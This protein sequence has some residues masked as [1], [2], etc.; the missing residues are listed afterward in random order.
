[1]HPDPLPPWATVSAL[2]VLLTSVL[3]LSACNDGAS[4][5]GG[6]DGTGDAGV[7][8]LSPFP[9]YLTYDESATLVIEKTRDAALAIDVSEAE[10]GINV[11]TGP[12]TQADPL[13]VE[14]R[15]TPRRSALPGR[16]R[17]GVQY[18]DQP[19]P[20][21]FVEFT[22]LPA[23]SAPSAVQVVSGGVPDAVIG[24]DGR[25]YGL[26]QR[27]PFPGPTFP[28][29]YDD[30]LNQPF[31]TPIDN[32]AQWAPPYVVRTDG[33]AIEYRGD[34]S[35]PVLDE[36][37]EPATGIRA[38]APADDARLRF[39]VL[40]DGRVFQVF[41]GVLRNEWRTFEFN[42]AQIP[43]DVVQMA[44][45]RRSS[46][47]E[48]TL[49]A[50]GAVWQYGN[51]TPGLSAFDGSSLAAISNVRQI[52]VGASRLTFG[53]ALREDGTVWVWLPFN[54]GARPEGQPQ[55]VPGLAAIEQIDVYEDV[56]LA[57]NAD[58]EVWQV[59][60]EE[61]TDQGEFRYRRAATRVPGITGARDIAADDRRAYAVLSDCNGNG[62]V[63]AWTFPDDPVSTL[64]ERELM[65]GDGVNLI[66]ALGAFDPF[67]AREGRASYAPRPVIGLGE[68]STPCPRRVL[69]YKSGNA[70]GPEITVSSDTGRMHC[71]DFLCA[72]VIDSPLQ[73]PSLAVEINSAVAGLTVTPAWD[74]E[75]QGLRFTLPIFTEDIY[76]KL[77]T[78]GL[79]LLVDQ[80]TTEA[81][82][83][84][85]RSAVGHRI[86]SDPPGLFALGPDQ[87]VAASTLLAPGSALQLVTTAAEGYEFDRWEGDCSE[88]GAVVIGDRNATCRAL[89][90]AAD[91][92]PPPP[93]PPAGDPVLT[94]RIEGGPGAGQVFGVLAANGLGVF[95][96]VNSTEVV[97]VCTETFPVGT[98]LDL[99]AS[100][101]RAGEGVRWSGCDSASDADGT[102]SV[103]LPE[104][105]EIT[106]SFG[107]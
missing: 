9:D 14:W 99:T 29:G 39:A 4:D 74:C 91:A 79:R 55:P 56:L 35:V 97:S 38:F 100:A 95:E 16:Y 104:D 11:D 94:V 89:F 3:C 88:D 47:V 44:V 50:D 107:P 31:A 59:E 46:E 12:C 58:G 76:C 25:L 102:C 26:W 45:R 51:Q 40:F 67:A 15:I 34:R 84:G 37:G 32:V 57:R 13:C 82:G 69:F 48:L 18:L 80:E 8:T 77:S 78:D 92:P 86:E 7:L 41:D 54:D 98:T 17:I 30:P 22:L 62:T 64:N 96:C 5:S 68:G 71:D 43:A 87:D 28:L 19:G 85:T 63:L 1:M 42:T 33:T 27:F 21:N 49:H 10:L 83:F 103:T 61:V 70:K 75:G 66:T 101:F 72:E 73:F 20:D 23:A 53:V 105:R 81:D 6:A 106:A 52:A 60:F 65:T 93:P 24:S 90:I 2:L 36:D